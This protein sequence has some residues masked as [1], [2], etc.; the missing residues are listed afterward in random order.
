MGILS[1]GLLIKP[2]QADFTG[3]MFGDGIYFADT[4][5]KSINYCTD[6][7]FF[8][9]ERHRFVLVCEV[10]LGNIKQ[11]IEYSQDLKTSKLPKGYDSIQGMGRQG[12][13]Y[14]FLTTVKGGLQVPLGKVIDYPVPETKEKKTT[15]AAA[16]LNS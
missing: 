4:F 6:W 11:I 9:L 14:E 10:I 3:D 7:N 13:D 12:P 16:T 15:A 8:G 1:Q 2:G 5:D